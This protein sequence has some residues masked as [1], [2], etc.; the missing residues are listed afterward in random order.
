MGLNETTKN[1]LDKVQAIS[2]AKDSIYE[3]LKEYASDNGY[4]ENA[5]SG[6][7]EHFNQILNGYLKTANTQK[8]QTA[9]YLHRLD[10]SMPETI[11]MSQLLSTVRKYV[12]K[13][14]SG[15]DEPNYIKFIE[16]TTNILFIPKG[17]TT[18]RSNLLKENNLIQ[19]I[20]W[21]NELTS[22]S[23][24]SSAFQ[25]SKLVALIIPEIVVSCGSGV[26]SSLATLEEVIWES[27]INIPSSF[28]SSCSI[29]KKFICTHEGITEIGS[30]A[31][32]LCYKLS[33]I[34]FPT[35]LQKIGAGAFSGCYDLTSFPFPEGLT[36]IGTGAF[37]NSGLTSL[38]LPKSLV[39]IGQNAFYYT[40]IASLILGENLEEL[41]SSAFQSCSSLQHVEIK[42]QKLK[43][44]GSNAFKGCTVLT[45]IVLP[46]GLVTIGASAFYECTGLSTILNSSLEKKLPK[47]LET[48]GDQ[49]FYKVP[50]KEI[51][52]PE[53][54][55][56]IGG[57]AFSMTQ[58]TTIEVPKTVISLGGG[59]FSSTPL[60]NATVGVESLSNSLFN[61]CKSL[62]EVVAMENIFFTAVGNYCFSNCSAL[63]TIELSKVTSVGMYAFQE[64][65]VLKEL[66]L[67]SVEQIGDSAFKNAKLESL[68]LGPNFTTGSSPFDGA[69][70]EEFNFLGTIEDWC[71]KTFSSYASSP[72]YASKMIK[73]NGN[74][75]TVISEDDTEAETLSS[76][77]FGYLTSLNDV[78][79][80]EV[81]TLEDRTFWGCTA[82]QRAHL[83]K[84]QTTGYYTFRDCTSLE[85]VELGSYK[86]PVKKIGSYSFQYAS[87]TANIVIWTEGGKRLSGSPWSGNS[88]KIF[89]VDSNKTKEEQ[90]DKFPQGV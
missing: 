13:I 73:F 37:Y 31:F 38:E 56:T 87:Q 74:L 39:S 90:L 82:L 78:H 68:I 81:T 20:E 17:T 67:S 42:S 43:I 27:T 40:D 61:G 41:S 76:Y 83:P 23:L 88:S 66:N 6:N 26:C 75:L 80:K 19:Y 11:N 54:V 77:I 2:E 35:T 48:I 14:Q 71:G 8:K 46:D 47:N 34:Q 3:T 59:A 55:K 62:R 9:K 58:L 36:E 51:I 89:Y 16:G 53:S 21:D 10:N 5:I 57:S 15:N 85:Y 12:N 50:L 1:I 52:F 44:I 30:N 28:A 22:I 63:E 4:D 18:I 69:T 33:E 86:N 70:I 49:A 29:L 45:D 7:L 60:I 25:G 24:Q 64:C 65:Q 84:L 32:N 79:L 72:F